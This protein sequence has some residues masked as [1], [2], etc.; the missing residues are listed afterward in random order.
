MEECPTRL[1]IATSFSKKNRVVTDEI[2]DYFK[3]G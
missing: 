3:L 2:I 1:T